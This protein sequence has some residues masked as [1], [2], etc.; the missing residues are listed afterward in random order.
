MLYK[1][2]VNAAYID[3]RIVEV[4]LIDFFSTRIVAL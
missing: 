3:L 2:A 1:M 4:T